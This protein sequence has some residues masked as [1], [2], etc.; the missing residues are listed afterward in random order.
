ME[1]FQGGTV[2]GNGKLANISQL[3]QP[4]FPGVTVVSFADAFKS[5]R[6]FVSTQGVQKLS[7]GPIVHQHPVLDGND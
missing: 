6:V 3:A 2:T 7:V 4:S 1:Y 5:H